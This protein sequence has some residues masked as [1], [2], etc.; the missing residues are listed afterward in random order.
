MKNTG[1][2]MFLGLFVFSL[3]VSTFAGDSSLDS[4]RVM[5]ISKGMKSQ[6]D[7][8][9]DFDKVRKLYD[10]TSPLIPA[11]NDFQHSKYEFQFAYKQKKTPFY[12]CYYQQISI[13]D[14]TGK[15]T[16]IL[17]DIVKFT[18][19]WGKGDTL[20]LSQINFGN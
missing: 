16:F 14:S 8:V 18:V 5:E 10:F 17:D 11:L 6:Y 4:A 20:S 7:V 12:V 9:F 2:I 13:Q 15:K 19:L 3:F 1:M